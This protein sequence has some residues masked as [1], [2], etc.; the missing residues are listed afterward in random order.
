MYAEIVSEFL[1]TSQALDYFR[2]TDTLQLFQTG[3]RIILQRQENQREK[4]GSESKIKVVRLDVQIEL[5]KMPAKAGG[6]SF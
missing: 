6:V 3:S 2:N 5:F 1:E 4:E